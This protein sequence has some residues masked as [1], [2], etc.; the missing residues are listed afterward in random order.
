MQAKLLS[1]RPHLPVH[2]VNFARF[3]NLQSHHVYIYTKQSKWENQL[4]AIQRVK[5][6]A[7][8]IPYHL[9]AKGIPANVAIMRTTDPY[10]A[11]WKLALW[12]W[13][14]MNPKVIGIT[15][16]AGKSTTTA[17]VAAI[18]RNHFRM[19]RTQGNLNT[20]SFLPN[21]L[22][23]LKENHN[24]LLLEIGMK[25]LNNIRRQCN[26]VRPHI[27]AVTNV[28]EAHAGSLGGLRQVVKAKQELVEGV[29][30][31]GTLYINADDIRSKQ[32]SLQRAKATIRTFGI[33]NDADVR[34]TN[35][36]YSPKGITFHA[37]VH[38][39]RATFFVPTY[40]QHNVYNALAAIG[41]ASS[42]GVSL[43]NIQRGLARFR[44][45]KMRLQVLSSK[46]GRTLINDA[47]NAN[48]TAMKAGL[49]VLQQISPQRPK[50]A[51][52][53]DMLELGSISDKSHA[54]IGQYVATLDID[55]LI[56]IGSR[57]R[58]IA[59]SALKHGMDR[60]KVFSYYHHAPLIAHLRNR[61]P[62]HAVIY[63]KASRKL[64]L[65]KVVQALR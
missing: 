59:E 2:E 39:E 40:G 35:I 43:A 9:S 52:L 42:M 60:R 36:Q 46:T 3:R 38:G 41:I 1:G 47:W 21:Y 50:I 61:T 19:V 63:F 5:P 8:V 44:T 65:E 28:G 48:P 16:S 4:A 51:V 13:R 29:R 14:Q 56:T 30:A 10:A 45:P 54:A 6:L 32:L 53:G 49:G 25:S 17:M 23:Q 11:Y 37:I 34:A 57:G 15:G 26:I 33:H 24:L 22:I 12:N 55:Q 7:V 58:K 20:W 31:G 64:H 18:L 27:G 62:R